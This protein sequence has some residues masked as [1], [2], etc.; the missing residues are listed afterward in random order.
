MITSARLTTTGD[1]LI[2]QS[3][4]TN[5]ITTIIVCNTGTPNLTDETV[6]S[7]IISINIT[8]SAPNNIS[9]DA[10]TIVK[11]LTVPAG[12]TVVFSEERMVLDNG[13]QLRVTASQS[14]LISV[15]VSTLPV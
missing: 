12:E 10:N 1:T 8:S 7:A 15:T 13:N 4:G 5:A 6:N 14:N 3:T 2:Y 9:N 11:N